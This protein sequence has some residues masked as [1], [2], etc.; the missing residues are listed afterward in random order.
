MA[1]SIDDRLL[2]SLLDAHDADCIAVETRRDV[3]R[4]CADILGAREQPVVGLTLDADGVPVLACGDVRAVVGAGVR[5]YLLADDDLLHDLREALGPR[6]ALEPGTVR[7]W[8]P[9][10]GVRCDPADHP[11]VLALE[12]EPGAVTLEELA[13]RFDLTRPRVRAQ[14]RLIEDARAFVEHELT[15]A[16]QQ[17]H[18]VHERLRDAQI[19]CHALR[20]RAEAAEASLAAAQR[21]R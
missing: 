6:L 15:L 10:A 3:H 5:I 2:S 9:G 4:M 1:H 8:W 18:K 11:A 19:E 7:V 14:I 20:T 13:L 21:P 12:G 16:Q 17:S